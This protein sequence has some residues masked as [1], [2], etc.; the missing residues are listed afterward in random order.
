MEKLR[1]QFNKMQIDANNTEEAID[2]PNETNPDSSLVLHGPSDYVILDKLTMRIV[3]DSTQE[4]GNWGASTSILP[5]RGLHLTLYKLSNRP[6]VHR[7]HQS[8][9]QSSDQQTKRRMR[10]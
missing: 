1:R 6:L 3:K 9:T 4:A 8:V 2:R 7:L 10:M 5:P